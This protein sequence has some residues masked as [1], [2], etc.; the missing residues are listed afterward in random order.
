MMTTGRGATKPPPPTD[1]PAEGI[2]AAKLSHTDAQGAARMVDVSG[3][4]V[5]AR[6]AEAAATVTVSPQAFAAIKDNRLAKG[7]VL[8]VARLAGIQA[9]KRTAE[10]IPLC[11]PLPL[12]QV[13]VDLRLDAAGPAV[14]IRAVARARA[15]TGVE[16]E[17]LVAAAAAALALYDMI[18]AVDRTATIGP[19]G[20][21]RKSG[22]RHGPF[23]RDW[24][25]GSP[26]AKGPDAQ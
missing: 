8:A 23:R 16:M 14:E 22:G 6:E 17:A 25:P 19:L 7:D 21:V 24:P 9:A 3:K 10:W 12:D 11:H 1:A 20:V 4:P 15:A 5:T 2:L 18:K 26:K 13:S